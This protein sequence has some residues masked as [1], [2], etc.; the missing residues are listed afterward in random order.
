MIR[1]SNK[2]T[3]QYS[4]E[5][6]MEIIH[7]LR[8]E[9]GCPWDREQTHESLK[10]C[11]IE[12][13]YET[14]EA[15]N[16]VDKENL[17]EELGDILLQVALHSVIAE[18]SGDFEMNDIID[19]ISKKMIH[20]H[21]HVFGDAIVNSSGEVLKNWE[22]IKKEEKKEVTVSQSMEK[23]PKALPALI[24]AAKVQGH[25]KNAGFDFVDY[26]DAL[27]KVYEEINELNLARK[28]G[29]KSQIEKE[30]GDLLFSVVNLSR[31]LQEN[32]E[33][34][35]TNATDK[36]INRFVDVERLVLREG[37]HLCDMSIDELKALWGQ[38]K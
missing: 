12:E 25:A 20:R 6:F 36:F 37:K 17:C 22:D 19:G 28:V 29:D 5:E 13:C 16:N 8:S 31:F 26:E 35:L 15:I 33:N 3:N 38:V 18:E 34:S 27:N 4:F 30:F 32:A 23:V 24:R 9:N 21:P 1:P 2:E 14:V 10:S 7:V 11:L